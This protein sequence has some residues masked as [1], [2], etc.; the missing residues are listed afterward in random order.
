VRGS[1]RDGEGGGGP[2]P[3]PPPCRWAHTRRRYDKPTGVAVDVSTSTRIGYDGL[4]PN[5]CGVRVAPGTRYNRVEGNRRAWPRERSPTR[6][7]KQSDGNFP[8]KGND[9]RG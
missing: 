9:A 2:L 5:L 3:P 8:V 7:P 6:N 4:R 1:G